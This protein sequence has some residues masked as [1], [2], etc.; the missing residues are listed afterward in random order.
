MAI[1]GDFVIS[2]GMIACCDKKYTES[3]GYNFIGRSLGCSDIGN[4]NL[5][6]FHIDFAQYNTLWA[7][8][9]NDRLINLQDLEFF[10]NMIKVNHYLCR[11]LCVK[12]FVKEATEFVLCKLTYDKDLT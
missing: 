9:C 5:R 8:N 1:I 11:D 2:D 10:S 4:K 6:N 7:S 3:S 12:Q